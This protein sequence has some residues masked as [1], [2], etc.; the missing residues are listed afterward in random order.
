M[1]DVARDP[2]E[3]LLIL[4]RC[5]LTLRVWRASYRTTR[6]LHATAALS[7]WASTAAALPL[8]LALTLNPTPTLVPPL[9]PKP[10]PNPDSNSSPNPNPNPNPNPIPTQAGLLAAAGLHGLAHHRERLVEDHANAAELAAGLTELGFSVQTPQTNMVW[11]G[12]PDNIRVPFETVRCAAG[13]TAPPPPPAGRHKHPPTNVTACPGM[14]APGRRGSHLGGR[15]LR[16][17]RRAQPMGRGRQEHPLRD[18]PAD[19]ARR[20]ARAAHRAG[21][22]PEARVTGQ[23]SGAR[24]AFRDQS[25]ENTWHEFNG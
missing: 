6:S 20:R 1:R 9:N 15:R 18:A 23:G 11:C 25:A 5:V 2:Y 21:Q 4:R 24:T 10:N 13:G 17:S 7:W 14:C 16:W 8:A 3:Y 12:A 22:A 19:A